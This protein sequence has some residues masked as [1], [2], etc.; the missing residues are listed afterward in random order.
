MAKAFSVVEACE[1]EQESHE[2]RNALTALIHLLMFSYLGH[3]MRNTDIGKLIK[4]VNITLTIT[5][6]IYTLGKN[7]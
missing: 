7:L 4:T 3:A 5:Q 1:R 6:G 2:I